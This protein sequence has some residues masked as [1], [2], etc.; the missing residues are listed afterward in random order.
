MMNQRVGSVSITW[1]A[2]SSDR[3]DELGIT[4]KPISHLG[5][6]PTTIH[7]S[8]PPTTILGV[9]LTRPLLALTLSVSLPPNRTASHSLSRARSVANVLGVN[10]RS[11]ASST[12]SFCSW[13]QSLTST[14][15]EHTVSGASAVAVALEV[16][17]SASAAFSNFSD[18]P[19]D[20]SGTS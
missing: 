5:N 2:V 14:L 17:L 9:Y 3:K 15:G 1:A 7:Y 11:V 10:A 18:L 12:G 8:W 13:L 19:F 4:D 16:R 6:R 20:P